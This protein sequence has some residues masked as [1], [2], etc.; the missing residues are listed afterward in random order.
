MSAV[1]TSADIAKLV[2]GGGTELVLQEGDRLTEIAREM[3]KR[4][5]IRVVTKR[6]AQA[7]QAAQDE[8]NRAL[9]LEAENRRLAMEL[10]ERE[11]RLGQ[12]RQ[13]AAQ[14]AGF[15]PAAPMPA[16][17]REPEY[18]L[19]IAGGTCVLPEAGCM[20][21]NV[22][23]RD[24][25]IA[26]LTTGR[27]RGRQ[28][29]DAAGLHVLP[30]I[31]DP[32]THLGLFVPL[33][34]ELVSE[35]RSAILGGVTT[36]GTYFNQENGYLPFIDQLE[37]QIPALSRTDIIPHFAMRSE[38]QLQEMPLY[39]ARGMN[40]YKVY[41]CGVPGIYPNQEDGFI[42][43][44]MERMKTLPPEANPI[45]SIHCENTSICEFATED[46]Q[47]LRL[48]T[49][50]DW[51]K[52]HPNLA[53]G[54][55]VIRAAYFSQK[56][57]ARTYIVHSSTKEAMEALRRLKHDRLYVETTSPYL[58]L[59]TDS[60]I[61]AYGKMLPPIREP[62]S[63]KALWNGVRSGLIDTIGTDNT[64]MTSEEKKVS[65]GMRGAG[66]GYPTLGTHLVSV[67]NEGI[68]RQEIALTRLVAMMTQNPARIFGVYPRKGTLLPGADADVVLVDLKSSRTVDPAQLLSRSD[69]SLYQ[70]KTLRAWPCATIKGGRIAAWD[71]KLVDDGVRGA[72]L[73]H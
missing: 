6:E 41:M 66:A 27:P 30:G 47:S 59:D 28:E 24:G 1:I 70:G 2:R 61:G 9:A 14:P 51:N 5:N 71:G 35:T 49:L 48:D 22:C 73:R 46:M 23:I 68:F 17:V 67:L 8:E 4:E 65:A 42:L 44:T 63:R 36:I 11:L 45:L 32:H 53:E 18:D 26:A 39:S 56:L 20:R 38:Q 7:A 29:I 69:F 62:E 52:T 54:E 21:L 37:Q 43:K 50:E 34:D 40:S 33:E 16:P 25:K 60:D 19:V 55:A 12:E 10:R 57:N 3:V 31:I 64:V 15:R 58:C 13:S 72:A